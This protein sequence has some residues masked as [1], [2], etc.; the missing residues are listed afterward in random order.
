MFLKLKLSVNVAL[1]HMNIKEEWGLNFFHSRVRCCFRK[2]PHGS[3]IC[4]D[5]AGVILGMAE[6]EG[7]WAVLGLV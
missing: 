1:F 5:G 2:Q 4:R 3:S 7:S 6:G